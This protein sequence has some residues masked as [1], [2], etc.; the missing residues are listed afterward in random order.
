[1][2]INGRK[3]IYSIS[4]APIVAATGLTSKT[5]NVTIPPAAAVRTKKTKVK[6]KRVVPCASVASHE[7]LKDSNT[8][9]SS[10]TIYAGARYT[11]PIK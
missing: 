2:Y 9:L 4:P 7:D 11:R 5:K 6:K 1:M 10:N 3:K 8:P